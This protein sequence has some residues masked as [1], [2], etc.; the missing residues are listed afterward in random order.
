[1]HEVKGKKSKSQHVKRTKAKMILCQIKEFKEA[2]VEIKND[3]NE[4]VEVRLKESKKK[5]RKTEQKSIDDIP[6]LFR[7]LLS[8]LAA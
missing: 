8:R 6:M 5:N 2:Y 3:G 7:T 4:K 1:M